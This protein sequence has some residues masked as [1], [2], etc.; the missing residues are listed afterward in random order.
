[1]N[2]V[3]KEIEMLKAEKEGKPHKDYE[4]E[5]TSDEIIETPENEVE[6]KQEKKTFKVEEES[7]EPEVENEQE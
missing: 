1:M 6:I 3:D 4:V 2:A 5:V 7:D